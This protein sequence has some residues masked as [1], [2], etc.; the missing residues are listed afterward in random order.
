MAV[1]NVILHLPS[2]LFCRNNPV[3]SEGK[4]HLLDEEWIRKISLPCPYQSLFKKKKKK[5]WETQRQRKERGGG[6]E[7]GKGEGE[8]K[9]S[10]RGE[11]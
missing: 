4:F 1:G 9:N 11:N 10:L 5:K 3:S 2:R 8:K 7:K 6:K